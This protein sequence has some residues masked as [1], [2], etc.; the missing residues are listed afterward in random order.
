MGE[1]SFYNKAKSPSLRRH[2]LASWSLPHFWV[3][4]IHPQTHEREAESRDRRSGKFPPQK[5]SA[6]EVQDPV[7]LLLGVLGHIQQGEDLWA[8]REHNKG[9]IRILPHLE[10]PRRTW[11]EKCLAS[12]WLCRSDKYGLM[13]FNVL[14]LCF[15][16][17]QVCTRS[18][19]QWYVQDEKNRFNSLKQT[20][21]LKHAI[22][23]TK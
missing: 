12:T 19:M 18:S 6:E 20:N 16:H 4:L 13:S 9:T 1:T 17:M 11:G 7:H 10:T 5:E 3:T 21:K 22:K 8:H 2:W 14:Y 15:C 23:G